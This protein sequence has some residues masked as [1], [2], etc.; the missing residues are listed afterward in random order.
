MKNIKSILYSTVMLFFIF[1]VTSIATAAPIKVLGIDVGYAPNP[2]RDYSTLVNN[3]STRPTITELGLL[4]VNFTEVSIAEFSSVD[5]YNYDVL[6]VSEAFLS[7]S[8]MVR[9]DALL[10]G[11]KNREAYIDEWLFK[12]HGLVAL[13]DPNV[14][15]YDWLPDTIQPTIEPLTADNYMYIEDT[16][17]PVMA[18]ITDTGLSGWGASSHGK[19]MDT[20]GLDILVDDRRDNPITLAGTYGSGKVVLTLQDPNFHYYFTDSTHPDQ[21]QFVS[22]ALEWVS[23]PVPEPA[24]II[25]LGSSLIGL[26]YGTRKFK[27]K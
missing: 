12:G 24:T 11:L 15:A 16:S 5:L 4:D 2:Y 7:G 10:D 3:L 14:G 13:S 25:L 27:K 26:L 22:N 23:T 6:F 20:A 18:G 21:I 1:G 8:T 9:N 19:F 17:H